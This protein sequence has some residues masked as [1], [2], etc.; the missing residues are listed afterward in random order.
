L[1]PIYWVVKKKK[2][3]KRKPANTR[4]FYCSFVGLFSLKEAGGQGGIL[5]TNAEDIGFKLL[6][7][8]SERDERDTRVSS[9]FCLRRQEVF[10]REMPW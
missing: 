3:S 5:G 10:A 1:A 2:K 4:Y 8:G 9:L 6:S 7:S